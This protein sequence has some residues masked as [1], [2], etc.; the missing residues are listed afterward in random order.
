[1]CWRTLFNIII[2][3]NI[4]RKDDCKNKLE[5]QKTLLF[6]VTK[7]LLKWSFLQCSV[8]SSFLG[9]NNFLSTLF[10]NTLSLRSSLNM[11][12]QASQLYTTVGKI[13]VL[14][15]WKFYIFGE[16]TERQKILHQMIARIPWFQSTLH[17]SMNG[18]FYIN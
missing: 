2:P 4:L 13:I 18:D 8:T 12:D 10:S 9:P 1:M 17:F 15:N 3:Q 5:W 14:H 11:T 16:Q 7:G 6:T